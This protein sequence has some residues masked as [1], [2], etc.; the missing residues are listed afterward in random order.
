MGVQIQGDT[1]NV[2]ATK[3]TYS[4][5]VTIG[6]TLTYEDVTNID[7]V[8]LITARSG[9]EIGARPGV[10]ASISVDGNAIFSGITTAATL[11]ATTGIVTTLNVAGDVDIADKIIHTGD[12]DTAIRFPAADTIT[13]ETAGGE[14]LRIDSTGSL[15]AGGTPLTESDLNWGHDTYQRP[16]I[17]SGNTGGT[18]SDGAIVAATVTENPSDSRIGAFIFG[19]KTSST[20]GVSNSGLKAFIEGCTNTNVSDAWKT[21]GYMKFS[22]RA[23]NGSTPAERLRITSDGQVVVNSTSGAVLASSSSKLEVFNAT[24][25][26]IFVAN[27]TAAASQ[28]A[29]IIFAPANNVY[30]GKII[31]TSDEDFS[32]SANR[33]AHMAFYTRK[34]GTAAERLRIKS[35]GAVSLTSENTTG[36]LLK[37]GQDSASYSVIDT[38]YPTTNRTLYLNQETTHRSFVVWNKNGSDGYGFGLDNSGNFK[39]VSG[40]SE[41]MKISSQGYVTTPSTVSFQAYGGGNWSAGNYVVLT[42]TNWNDGSGYNTSNGVF[43][44]PVTGTY[45]FTITGLYTLNNVSPPHKIVWHVNNV[46]SGVLAEW[47]DGSIANSYNTIGNSSIIFK[48]SATNTVRIYV[49]SS[50]AHISGGQTRYCGHLIG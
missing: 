17:F 37:A 18:P 28:D 42:N 39:V 45:L 31:V 11:R 34:D 32:S 30:G 24:E 14:R 12:T 47:Q 8:G 49:E 3:G 46:N 48:L 9:I 36:W 20:S 13:A 41:R 1:G 7:S 6:G 44:A 21:G 23:D 5:N 19:C 33:T 15:F 43:T 10:G 29:G 22:T 27:S 38:H 35:D 26:H 40:S 50:T 16:H 2:I 4:G 25:N